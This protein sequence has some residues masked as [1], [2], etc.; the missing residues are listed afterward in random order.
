MVP[1]DCYRYQKLLKSNKHTHQ[2]FEVSVGRYV[3][4]NFSRTLCNPW[5]TVANIG[6]GSDRRF[7]S[8]FKTAAL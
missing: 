6:T 5:V 4:W 3:I 7:C 2:N 8:T 1:C